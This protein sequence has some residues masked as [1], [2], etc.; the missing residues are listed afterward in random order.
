MNKNNPIILITQNVYH[1]MCNEFYAKC[2][3]CRFERLQD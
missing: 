2:L 1:K 3:M